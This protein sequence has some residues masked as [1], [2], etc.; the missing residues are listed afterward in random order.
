M[1]KESPKGDYKGNQRYAHLK[2]EDLPLSDEAMSSLAVFVHIPKA[3]G[4]SLKNIMVLNYGKRYRDHHPRLNDLHK[5]PMQIGRLRAVSAHR[6]FGYHEELVKAYADVTGKQDEICEAK[7][8]QFSVVRNPL[9]R[10]I[11]LYNFVTTFPT[12]VCYE[13][14]KDLGPEDFFTQYRQGEC[15]NLQCRFLAGR[16]ND[17]TFENAKKNIE[18][19]FEIVV[20]LGSQDKLISH[21]SRKLGWKLPPE[22]IVAN[23]SPRKLT[24]SNI[25]KELEEKLNARMDEDWK[26]FD[27]VCETSS[28]LPK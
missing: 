3:G 24:R 16:G 8:V 28:K 25:S 13:E 27:Y 4:T 12:H 9:D 5:D 17:S 19:D 14:M 11:S 2:N 10:L 20:D 26:L 18:N 15:G 7:P 22:K 21:L 6:P 1:S 23:Q